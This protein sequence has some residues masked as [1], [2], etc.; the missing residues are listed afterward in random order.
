M[1]VVGEEG[2]GRE[3]KDDGSK[4]GR[5]ERKKETDFFFV[6]RKCLY[7]RDWRRALIMA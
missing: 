1:F 2:K 5:K 6:K 3:G 7:Q 4:E